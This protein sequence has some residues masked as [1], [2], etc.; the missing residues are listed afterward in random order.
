MMKE[1]CF[2][3]MPALDGVYSAAV[4]NGI[5]ER[6]NWLYRGKSGITMKK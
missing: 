2:T 1:I 5:P 3:D 4:V 6:R